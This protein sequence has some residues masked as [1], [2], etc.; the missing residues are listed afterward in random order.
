MPGA[1][2]VRRRRRFAPRPSVPRVYAVNSCCMEKLLLTVGLPA[3]VRRRSRAAESRKALNY[4]PNL[5]SRAN[6]VGAAGLSPRSPAS[7][8]EQRAHRLLVGDARHRLG[9]QLCA[10]QLSDAL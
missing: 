8:G 10:G 3:R 6:I 9:K 4:N 2:P 7:L 5:L 1:L